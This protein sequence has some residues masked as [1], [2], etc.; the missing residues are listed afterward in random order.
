VEWERRSI[1]VS[2]PS[3]KAV[4]PVDSA[5]NLY[6]YHQYEADHAGKLAVQYEKSAQNQACRLSL[7]GIVTVIESSS[8]RP[9][10]ER[11]RG[12]FAP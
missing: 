8:T 9:F 7:L 4:R 12:V 5:R 10:F 3:A 6:Q 2:G 11:L 1:D